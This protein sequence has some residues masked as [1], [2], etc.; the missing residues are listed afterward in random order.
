MF[1]IPRFNLKILIMKKE[2][3]DINQ[4]GERSTIFNHPSQLNS[5]STFSLYRKYGLGKLKLADNFQYKDKLSLEQDLNRNYYACGCSEGS[6]ALMLFSIGSS[7]YA[8]FKYFQGEHSLILLGTYVIGI[9]IAGAIFGKWFG[10]Y[11]ANNN[12]KRT[13][14]TIQAHWKVESQHEHLPGVTCG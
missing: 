4:F 12:L 9:S 10:L 8:G 2:N 5:L 7:M 11:K 6:K 14:H 3:S 13:V 1:L